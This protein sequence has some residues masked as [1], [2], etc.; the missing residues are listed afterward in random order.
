MTYGS[1]SV[2]NASPSAARAGR[3]EEIKGE[4]AKSKIQGKGESVPAPK[5]QQQQQQKQ[6]KQQQQQ[7]QQ[8]KQKQQHQSVQQGI[9]VFNLQVPVLIPISIAENSSSNP[10]ICTSST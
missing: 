4:D 2:P 3:E 9:R 7:Q 10:V 5:R 6:Q 1:D 8:P